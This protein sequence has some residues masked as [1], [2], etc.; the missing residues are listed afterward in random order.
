MLLIATIIFIL[1]VITVLLV[2]SNLKMKKIISYQEKIIEQHHRI[3]GSR[4]K[5]KLHKMADMV[6]LENAS[7]LLEEGLIY[8]EDYDIMKDKVFKKEHHKRKT[9]K[10][11]SREYK[12]KAG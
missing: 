2:T 1:L 3:S 12:E 7:D 5:E 10:L 8:M 9:E 11:T 6:I 4:L